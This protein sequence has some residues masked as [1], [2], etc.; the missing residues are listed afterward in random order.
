MR[1]IQHEREKEAMVEEAPLPHAVSPADKMLSK[2][3]QTFLTCYTVFPET[4][5]WASEYINTATTE[6]DLSFDLSQPPTK[7][8]LHH[9]FRRL[10]FLASHHLQT[11][12]EAF[13][14]GAPREDAQRS[15]LTSCHG[16]HEVGGGECWRGQRPCTKPQAYVVFPHNYFIQKPDYGIMNIFCTLYFSNAEA[17]THLHFQ[18]CKHWSRFLFR[19]SFK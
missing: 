16:R 19:C 8:I 3:C 10:M 18:S 12:E 5:S 11:F 14:T 4:G 2:I 7:P 17:R 1:T 13:Y 6:M 9:Y 15:P